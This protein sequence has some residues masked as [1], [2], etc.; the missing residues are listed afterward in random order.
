MDKTKIKQLQKKLEGGSVNSNMWRPEEGKNL[1]RIIPN[2]FEPE[3]N[4]QSLK[5]HYGV[6][7]RSI[8]CLK[9]FNEDCPICNFVSALFE[10]DGEHAEANRERAKKIMA[11][12]RYYTPIVVR[13]R[14]R[15]GE[16]VST[17]GP[18]W[19]GISYTN[20]KVLLNSYDDFGDFTDVENGYDFIVRYTKKV[21]FPETQISKEERK[22]LSEDPEEAAEFVENVSDLVSNFEGFKLSEEDVEHKLENFLSGKSVE[23]D[24]KEAKAEEDEEVKEKDQNIKN[25]IDQIL[26]K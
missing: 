12:E 7:N 8:L 24:E 18:Y 13:K 16:V 2:K 4:F 26:K 19:F 1:I 17:D 25:K 14:N 3:T 9:N 6:G 23:E 22:P 11:K 20:L 5:F 10:S 15:Q 21:P